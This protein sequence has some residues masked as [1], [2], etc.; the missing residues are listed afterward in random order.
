M[1]ATHWSATLAVPVLPHRDHIQLPRYIPMH[2]LPPKRLKPRAASVCSGKC[3][4]RYSPR[5][6]LSRMVC[7][8]LL[9]RLLA[10]TCLRFRS[11]RA[12]HRS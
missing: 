10:L 3:T 7:S 8:P 5:T 1:N 12:S 11:N 4:L 2:R 6:R 9:Q